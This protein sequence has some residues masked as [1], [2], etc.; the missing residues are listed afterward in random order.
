MMG[1]ANLLASQTKIKKKA[2]VQKIR[3]RVGLGT[4]LL[5]FMSGQMMMPGLS[6]AYC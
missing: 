5:L 1:G 4:L 3:A 2:Q 6:L